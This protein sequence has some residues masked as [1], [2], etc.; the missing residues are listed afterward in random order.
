MIEKTM[1]ITVYVAYD[2]TEF[3]TSEECREYEQ[4]ADNF[5][6]YCI[7][8]SIQY[9]SGD[10][11][12]I[13]KGCM[14]GGSEDTLFTMKMDSTDKLHALLDYWAYQYKGDVPFDI[15]SR[16]TAAREQNDI[17]LFDF[18]AFDNALT[19]IGTLDEVLDGI[20]GDLISLF[21]KED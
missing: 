14:W 7:N 15:T 19:Y 3:N 18:Y 9:D 13:M 1:T 10:S 20:R 2:G 8:N 6:S 4:N 11:V 5:R 16:L 12:S 17:V 21:R